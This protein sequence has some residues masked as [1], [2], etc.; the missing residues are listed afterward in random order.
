MT[1]ERDSGLGGPEVVLV[2]RTDK[3]AHWVTQCAQGELPFSGPD[4]LWSRVTALGYQGTSLYE[5]VL[6]EERRLEIKK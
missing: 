3:I 4:S 6:A 2:A 5:M 1:A